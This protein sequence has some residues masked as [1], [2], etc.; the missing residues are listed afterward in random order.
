MGTVK[1]LFRIILIIF[2]LGF[3]VP[4][5][6]KNIPKKKT[7]KSYCN[8]QD[9]CSCYDQ[10]ELIPL[11]IAIAVFKSRLPAAGVVIIADF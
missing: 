1:A 5:S 3:E 9:G 7:N 4:F 8:S 2:A 10:H 6:C 11:I